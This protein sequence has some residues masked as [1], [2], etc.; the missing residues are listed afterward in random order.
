MRQRCQTKAVS[1]AM[2]VAMPISP[3]GQVPDP[4]DAATLLS[5]NVSLVGAAHL[6]GIDILTAQIASLALDL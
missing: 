6:F 4:T 3:S 2:A 1:Q 5:H